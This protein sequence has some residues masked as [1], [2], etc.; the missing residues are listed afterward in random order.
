MLVFASW[1][2]ELLLEE[3]GAGKDYRIDRT[4]YR[5]CEPIVETKCKDKGKKDGDVM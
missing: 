1:Q 4:L 2:V 3:T 5:A